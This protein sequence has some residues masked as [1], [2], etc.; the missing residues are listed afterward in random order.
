M[1]KKTDRLVYKFALIFFNFTVITLVISGFMTYASQMDTYKKLCMQNS[2]ALG[3][4][5]EGLMEH[6]GDMTIEYKEYFMDHYREIEMP[7]DFDEYLTA[8]SKFVALFTERYPGLTFGQDIKLNELDEDVRECYFIYKHQYWVLTFEHARDAFGLPYVYFLVMG[9]PRGRTENITPDMGTAEES[10]VYMI[11]GERTEVKDENG[12]GTGL[13]YLGDT[14]GNYRKN[15]VSEWKTWDTGEC[16]DTFDEFNNNWGH[17]YGYYTPLIING[18]KVGLIVTELEVAT[19]NKAILKN[20]LIYISGIAA[21]LIVCMIVM[22]WF[23]NRFYIHRL[24]RLEANVIDYTQN[25]NAEV[26]EK[27]EKLITSED[28]I[29]SLSKQ[30]ASMIRELDHHISDMTRLSAERERFGAEL[31]VATK[32][33]LDM[34]PKDFPKRQD[35]NMYALM[36]PAKEV[37]GDFYD[38]FFIDSNHLGLVMA[39]VSGKGVPAALFMVIAKTLISNRAMMGGSPSRVLEDVNFSLCENNAS[40]M[41]ITAWLG[42]L[43]LSTG[44]L[45]CANAGHEYPALRHKG[46]DFELLISDHCPPL[47]S[48]DDLEYEDNTIMLEPGDS[49]FIYTDGIP[50]AKNENGKHLG[51]KKMLEILNAAPGLGPK[52][53]LDGLRDLVADFAKGTDTFDDITMMC[54]N[55]LGHEK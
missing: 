18:Q 2:R 24:R 21:V 44:K 32:I 4:Y 49:L 5:L 20:T 48:M 15:H 26:T 1:G 33:Q 43:T 9:D 36:S 23:I 7:Y 28:E 38:F 27:I 35:L 51:T 11:D 45:V 22:L 50:D 6:E 47:A 30:T 37:G 52:E 3:L 19:I 31:N 13:L 41:F 8:Q 17:T 29:S 16:L 42:I 40:G 46:G 14:Y 54:I 25:K 12:K 55:Y 10:V 39:D 34:M 53:L